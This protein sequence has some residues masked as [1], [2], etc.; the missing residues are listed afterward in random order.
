MRSVNLIINMLRKFILFLFISVSFFKSQ[1]QDNSPYSRYGIGDLISGQNIVNRGMGGFAAAYSDFG[2]V[3]APFNI[4]LV[5]PASLGNMSNTKNF[6]NTIFDIGSEVDI[7]NLKSTVTSDKYK[8]TNVVISYLQLAFPVSSP[9]MEKRGTS[10]GMSF[11]L[12]PISRISYKI[13]QNGRINNIDSTNTIYEGSGGVNQVNF[14]TGIRKTGKGKNNN[15]ISFGITSGYTFGTKDY[16]TRLSLVNDSV[17]YY[18]G[19]SELSGRFGGVFLNAGLQYKINIKKKGALRLGAYYNLQQ[20]LNAKQSTI[21]ETYTYDASGNTVR[22]DSVSI[23]NDVKGKVILPSTFGAGFAYQSKNHN[24]LIGADYEMTHWSD[25][26][27]YDQTDKVAN[28]WVI[29]A[30]VEYYPA[31]ENSATN[32]Y[33]DYVKYRTGFYYGP[34]YLKITGIRN[35][36]AVTFGAGLPLTTPRY[37]Q[38]RGEY[39]S[40][41]TSIELGARGDRNSFGVRENFTRFNFGISMNARWFQKRN[42]D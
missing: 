20:N 39:V 2:I 38:S 27:Y 17:L 28:N 6:S 11:G 24:W 4:N 15:E 33:R 22:V 25:Y 19:N 26:K 14:S 9:K 37:I 7:R 36:Y 29:R 18:R 42:Y 34:D 8:S 31:K 10:L 21:N 1:A 3:G 12:K 16:S 32:K 30:G 13:E 41:N 5:N 35:N 23:L 40:L